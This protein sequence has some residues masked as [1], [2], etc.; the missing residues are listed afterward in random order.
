[1]SHKSTVY[2]FF[3]TNGDLVP[4]LQAVESAYGVS[5][6]ECGLFDSGERPVVH[7]LSSFPRLG[8]A[9][10]GDFNAEPTF[11][12]LRPEAVL[13][14]R[15]VPQRRGG[16]KFAVDQLGN[17][18]TIVVKP[19]GI[20]DDSAVISGMVGTV[21]NDNDSKRL[22]A[23]FVKALKASFTPVKSYLVGPEAKR[24]LDA[25]VRLTKSVASPSE[26]DLAK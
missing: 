2:N 4:A 7:S 19:A 25:G 14:V 23:V 16:V 24:L 21:H 11:L 15:E 9:K 13:N 18:G 12:V 22:M 10:A 17:P 20:Y 8:L 1:M 26:F 6:V 5:Y 3:A